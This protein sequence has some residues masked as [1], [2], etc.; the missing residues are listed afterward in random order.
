MVYLQIK[1]LE[2]KKVHMKFECEKKNGKFDNTEPTSHIA[3]MCY[4]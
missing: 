1:D 2:I 3:V 4:I